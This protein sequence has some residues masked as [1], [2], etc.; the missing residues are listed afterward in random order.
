MTMKRSHGFH[1][2]TGEGRFIGIVA[3][4]I[5]MLGTM[6][7]LVTAPA[8]NAATATPGSKIPLPNPSLI[9]ASRGASLRSNAAAPAAAGSWTQKNELTGASGSGLGWS[10]A[11]SG[12]TMVVGAPFDNAGI[13]A[14]YVYTGSGTSWTEKAELTP[15]GGVAN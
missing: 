10:V 6:V 12:G 15:T 13:G 8:A 2:F 9:A 3:A 7:L 14:A 1:V 11:V 4:I 5:A